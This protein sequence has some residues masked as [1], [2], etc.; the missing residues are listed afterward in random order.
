MN[1][2]CIIVEQ[3]RDGVFS[4]KQKERIKGLFDLAENNDPA[5]V[6]IDGIQYVLTLL[7]EE[8]RYTFRAWGIS[9]EKT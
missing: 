8:P 5:I 7:Q 9:K 2:V 1:E 6:E 4:D 3:A